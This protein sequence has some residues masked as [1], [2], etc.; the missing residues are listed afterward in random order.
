MANFMN[1]MVLAEN[2]VSKLHNW[3][4]YFNANATGNV[5]GELTVNQTL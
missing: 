1:V 2:K 4:F 3:Q 5:P